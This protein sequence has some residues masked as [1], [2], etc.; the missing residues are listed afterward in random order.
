MFQD[1]DLSVFLDGIPH[2]VLLVDPALSVRAMNRQGEAMT[3][4]SLKEVAGIGAD[5]VIRSNLRPFSRFF[6]A[7]L[8]DRQTVSQEGNVLDRNRK[9]APA[10]FTISPVEGRDGD[11][12]GAMVVVEDLSHTAYLEEERAH[13]GEFDA[14]L[15]LNPK[16]REIAEKMPVFA[17]TD[18]SLLIE[19]ETGTGKGSLAETVHKAS[20]RAGYPY[21][22]VNCAA[23]PES[24]L[25]SELFGHAPGAFAGAERVRQG[26]LRLADHGT[27]F[28]N[29]IGDMPLSMQAKLLSVLD[30]GEF[31]PL[32]STRKVAVD[33]RIIAAT[34]RDLKA[35]VEEGL[36]REDLYYRLN[37]LRLRLP[38]LRERQ[39]DIP[40]L[41]DHFIR[42]FSKGAATPQLDSEA[43]G[44]LKAYSFPGNVRELRNMLEH[45]L[46]L[47]Q[48]ESITKEH[49][50]EYLRS[51]ESL[52]PHAGVAPGP[53]NAG[54]KALRW[55]DVEKEM[56]IDAL[57]EARGKK[58]EAA[59]K[60][61]WA[62]STLYRKLRQHGI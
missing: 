36:F 56:I 55:D 23:L 21:I 51:P 16:M 34:S 52:R 18:A 40:L 9:I 62:R 25:E 4:R 26:M 45:T 8:E 35:L 31:S 17:A 6:K 22:K 10:R 46:I 38:S 49:L 13:M 32:G 2:A 47:S 42:H 1:V 28:F 15:S 59:K 60:L 5:F 37:V 30:D 50:P 19:G 44:E 7:V 39:E 48:G 12:L 58:N 29:E 20:K 3:G 43:L 57:R 54:G 24:L 53:G 41:I 14:E 27:I 33:V 11:L 61:G